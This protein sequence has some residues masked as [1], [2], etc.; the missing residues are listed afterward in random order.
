MSQRTIPAFAQYFDGNGNILDGGKLYFFENNSSSVMQDTFKDPELT[1]VNTNPLILDGE[2]RAGNTYGDG[3]YRVILTDKND[4][5]IEVNDNINSSTLVVNNPADA[6]NSVVITNTSIGDDP[7]ISS[8]GQAVNVG[9]RLTT[10]AAG[11]LKV[12]TNG[13]VRA[14]FDDSGLALGT[15]GVTANTIL[16]EDTLGSDSDTALATQQSIKAY[17]DGVKQTGALQIVEETTTVGVSTTNTIPNDNT[18]PQSSEGAEWDTLT[19]TPNSSTST[20]VIEFNGMVSASSSLY[21]AVCLFEAAASADALA[22]I[23]VTNNSNDTA[24]AVSLSM[25]VASTGTS[26]RTFSIRFGANAGTAYASMKG[27]GD[28]L[29]A[30]VKSSLRVTEVEV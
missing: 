8:S 17:V 25:T 15:T 9:L 19:I 21:I 1:I 20:L 16:D 30:I 27:T 14:E 10:Q 6:V 12:E 13:I 29:G 5:Q 22:G 24:E 23:Q 18:I 26:A 3:V 2:G 11:T 7:I 4:V 28:R